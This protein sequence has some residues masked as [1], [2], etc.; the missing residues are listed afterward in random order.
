MRESLSLR[1]ENCEVDSADIRN[2][3]R[4]EEAETLLSI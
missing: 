1:S 3:R 2:V 4:R